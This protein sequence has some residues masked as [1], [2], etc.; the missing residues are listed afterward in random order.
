MGPLSCATYTV[1]GRVD[2]T[3]TVDVVV[4]GPCVDVDVWPDAPL[5]L[6]DVSIRTA[7]SQLN[8]RR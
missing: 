4:T 5:A 7:E 1:A 2:T 6:V 8:T 3:L